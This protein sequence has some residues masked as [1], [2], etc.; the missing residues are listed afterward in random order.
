MIRLT[1]KGITQYAEPQQNTKPEG[2][3]YVDDSQIYDYDHQGEDPSQGQGSHRPQSSASQH[4]SENG[5]GDQNQQYGRQGN[6][7]YH[8]GRS[9]RNDHEDDDDDMW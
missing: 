8:Y 6:D 7:Y 2:V 4:N 5:Y 3:T 9:E 1:T